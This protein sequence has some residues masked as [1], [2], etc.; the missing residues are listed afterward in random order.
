[1]KATA[2]ADYCG[3]VSVK[4]LYAAARS[5]KLRVARI[6]AGRNWL[7]CAEWCDEWLRQSA[8]RREVQA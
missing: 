8:Q 2:A 1:M 4:L 7:T 3:G 5:G 6:G